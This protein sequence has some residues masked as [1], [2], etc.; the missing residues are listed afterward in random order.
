MDK[1]TTAL[2]ITGVLLG[3]CLIAACAACPF[4]EH[5]QI[6]MQGQ[7]A[8][9]RVVRALGDALKPMK[10]KAEPCTTND[11]DY[12]FYQPAP[13]PLGSIGADHVQVRLQIENL[14]VSLVD[15]DRSETQLARKVTS[16]IQ[17][18]V[19]SELGGDI[20]FKKEKIAHTCFFGP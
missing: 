15:A 1:L 12:L 8:Q 2:R 19:R 3:G 11:C 10:F 13:W 6:V 7:I 14:T 4:Y 16:A 20:S 18:A 9:E 17:T 5:G